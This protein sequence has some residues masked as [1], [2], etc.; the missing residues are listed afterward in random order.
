MG[1]SAS[2]TPIAPEQNDTKEGSDRQYGSRGR[3]Q[4]A[5]LRALQPAA[6]F[7]FG[8]AFR[9]R[10]L[11]QATFL[12]SAPF[13]FRCLLLRFCLALA[14][15]FILARLG[16]E[17]SDPISFRLGFALAPVFVGRP[18]P[19]LLL[20]AAFCFDLLVPAFRLGLSVRF[21]FLLLPA[22]GGRNI[23]PA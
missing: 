6:F 9:L 3:P 13:R 21:S 22:L 19:R 16:F 2:H 5:R 20:G 12:G 18:L 8:A 7:G 1:D 4:R 15:L 23:T 11:L 14:L 17:R 10:L